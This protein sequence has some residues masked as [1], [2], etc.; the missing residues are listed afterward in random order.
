MLRLLALSLLVQ[1]PSPN[2]PVTT[3]PATPT[4]FDVRYF[5]AVP[6]PGGADKTYAAIQ[7]I[8]AIPLTGG[9]NQ[10]RVV[11]LPGV[12]EKWYVS[13]SIVLDDGWTDFEGDGESSV[14]QMTAG[15]TDPVL[16]IGM[17]RRPLKKSLTPDHGIDAFGKLDADAVPAANRRFGFRTLGNSRPLQF[18]GPLANGPPP[19]DQNTPPGYWGDVAQF[20]IDHCQDLSQASGGDWAFGIDGVFKVMADPPPGN[21]TI[22]FWTRT[23]GGPPVLNHADI[24]APARGLQRV[25]IQFDFDTRTMTAYVNGV[26]VAVT[27]TWNAPAGPIRLAANEGNPYCLGSVS[28][29]APPNIKGDWVFYGHQL[30]TGLRYVNAGVGQPQ[31]RI[32]GVAI[33]DTNRFFADTDPAVIAYFAFTNPPAALTERLLTVRHGPRTYYRNSSAF[34]VSTEHGSNFTTQRMMTIRRLQI[35]GNRG[36]GFLLPYGDAI[37]VGAAVQLTIEDCTISAGARAIAGWNWLANYWNRVSHC[38]LQGDDAA[39]YLYYGTWTA[40]D[41]ETD[42]N[43]RNTIWCNQ[44]WLDLRDHRTGE[45]G[46]PARI[47][48]AQGGVLRVFGNNT[49]I[50]GGTYPSRCFAES[51][52]DASLGEANLWLTLQDCVLGRFKPGIPLVICGRRSNGARGRLDISR[53]RLVGDDKEAIVRVDGDNWIGTVDLDVDLVTTPILK[54][55]GPT[56]TGIRVVGPLAP[57]MGGGPARAAAPVGPRGLPF[58][59][60]PTVRPNRLHPALTPPAPLPPNQPLAPRPPARPASRRPARTAAGT[61]RTAPSRPHSCRLPRWPAPP[62]P[63]RRY[64][65]TARSRRARPRTGSGPRAPRP[66]ST[67]N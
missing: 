38:R 16:V 43:G 42:W 65:A 22:W 26:Q 34:V 39:L 55:N 62:D 35:R 50:E 19:A 5:G 3:P 18:A 27:V 29:Q 58:T 32:D 44:S 8:L 25:S 47:Y 24:A 61:R 63:R 6:G 31:R 49:D 60:P 64:R 11:Y 9:E 17:G 21:W 48:Y 41:I 66:G 10:R 20:T 15:K 7:Q 2:P 40:N 14:L 4:R 56:V 52:P 28:P 33:T 59:P 57:T 12:K 1:L 67:A 51:L 36:P 46:Y 53:L 54:L 23:A 37:A 45:G 13:R 30:C